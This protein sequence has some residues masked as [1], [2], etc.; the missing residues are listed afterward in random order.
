M[1]PYCA[2]TPAYCA[3]QCPLAAPSMR[4]ACT[5]G[6]PPRAKPQ[7][8]QTAPLTRPGPGSTAHP[9]YLVAYMEGLHNISQSRHGE[10]KTASCVQPVGAS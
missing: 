7:S 8:L 5:T 6:V 10:R 3:V 1:P 4:P 9:G 2:A